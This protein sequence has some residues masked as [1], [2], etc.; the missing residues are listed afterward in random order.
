MSKGDEAAERKTIVLDLSYKL[1][2]PKL[3]AW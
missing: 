1:G 2:L 3:L